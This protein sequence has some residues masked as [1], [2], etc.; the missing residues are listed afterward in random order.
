[1]QRKLCNLF[2]TVTA[3]KQ[4]AD[5]LMPQIMKPKIRDVQKLARPCET[6]ANAAVVIGKDQFASLP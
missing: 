2:D 4:S 6:G 5:C 1:M 3:L